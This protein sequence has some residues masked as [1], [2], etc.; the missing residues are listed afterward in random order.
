MGYSSIAITI[1]RYGHLMPGS[2]EQAAPVDAYIE[3]AN[4]Q[5]RLAQV[6]RAPVARQIQSAPGHHAG[7][8]L[9][10]PTGATGL[11]PATYGFGDRRSTN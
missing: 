3:P 8:R 9:T 7:F 5:A 6:E 2:E 4:S 1:D 10:K 11:E